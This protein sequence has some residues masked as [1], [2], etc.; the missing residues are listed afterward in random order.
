MNSFTCIDISYLRSSRTLETILITNKQ[1]SKTL[2]VYNY[3]GLYFYVFKNL[4]ELLNFF[5]ERIE[6]TISFE[7][8]EELDGYLLEVEI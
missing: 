8:E 7:N 6:S 4:V 1:K 5:E 2:Y 3:E